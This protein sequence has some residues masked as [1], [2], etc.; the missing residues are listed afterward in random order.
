MIPPFLLAPLFGLPR[1][2]WALA[3]AALLAVAFL[4]W[5]NHEL[6]GSAT[7]TSLMAWAGVPFAWWLWTAIDVAVI[8]AIL[9]FGHLLARDIV[10]VAL[11]IPIWCLYATNLPYAGQG[12]NLMVA[13]QLLL[14]TPFKAIHRTYRERA[15]HHPDHWN[16]F[17]LRAAHDAA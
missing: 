11:F 14:T 12:V 5:L 10:I 2:L 7:V 13:F 17:D 15:Q 16:E 9:C 6:L 8:G 1:W 4:L 3:G